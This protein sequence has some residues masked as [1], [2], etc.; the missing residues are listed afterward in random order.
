MAAGRCGTWACK[1][2]AVAAAASPL[3]FVLSPFLSSLFRDPGASRGCGGRAGRCRQQIRLCRSRAAEA[4][5]AGG[6][7]HFRPIIFRS[8]RTAAAAE[9]VAAAAAEAAAATAARDI[10]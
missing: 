1:K 6:K 2:A 10:F 8:M 4:T 3:V 9:V 7:G 5:V